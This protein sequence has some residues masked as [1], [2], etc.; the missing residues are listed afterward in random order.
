MTTSVGGHLLESNLL[1]HKDYFFVVTS[2][3]MR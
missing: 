1:E 3:T 2:N